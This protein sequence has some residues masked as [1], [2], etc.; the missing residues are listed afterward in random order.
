MEY[1]QRNTHVPVGF[2]RAVGHSQNPF[3]RECFM[4]ELA[5][6]AGKDPYEFRRGLLAHE[7]RP[8]AVLEAAAKAAGWG[9]PLPNGVFRGIAL[10]EPYGSF[11]AAVIEASVSDAG[12]L[13]IHRIVSAVDCGYIVNP[14]T[15][16]AQMEGGI[17]FGLT[18]ALWG[19][20]TLDKGRV[21]QSNFGDYRMMRINEAPVVEVYIVNS[22][23]EPG[24]VGEPGTS[25]IAPAVTNA[26]FAATGTRIRKM[27]IG[28]QLKKA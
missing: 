14:D 10:T 18:A 19:E 9:K 16:I 8:L 20:I 25:G 5:H 17:I 15:V 4:D 2:W 28:E 11:T 21:Q 1:A 26:V 23:D 22:R 27:P 12:E 7:P 13:K 6:A 3:A 24:G